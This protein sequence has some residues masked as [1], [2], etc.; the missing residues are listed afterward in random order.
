MELEKPPYNIII[1][2][3]VGYF[4]QLGVVVLPAFEVCLS[5]LNVYVNCKLE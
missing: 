5:V 1:T 2:V 4:F 3:L